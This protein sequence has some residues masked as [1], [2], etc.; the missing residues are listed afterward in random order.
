MKATKHFSDDLSE[1]DGCREVLTRN[2]TVQSLAS[3]R[4]VTVWKL[5]ARSSAETVDT[6][7]VVN[8]DCWYYSTPLHYLLGAHR[9]VEFASAKS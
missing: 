5:R 4:C 2:F 1:P 9:C 3:C 8:F 6:R 7:S